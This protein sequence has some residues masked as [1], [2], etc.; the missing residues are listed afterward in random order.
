MSKIMD[1]SSEY[2]KIVINV[3]GL[4]G[5][6]SVYKK[7]SQGLR[8]FND[9]WLKH[10]KVDVVWDLRLV[11]NNRISIAALAFFLSIAHR[12]HHFTEKSQRV[13][14]NWHSRTLGFI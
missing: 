3:G 13:L 9:L 12:V 5:V 6:G 7:S 8:E 2:P 1:Y 10:R 11:Q 4:E 14:L